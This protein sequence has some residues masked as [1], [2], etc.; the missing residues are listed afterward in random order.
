LE[1]DAHDEKRPGDVD[2]LDRL[3]VWARSNGATVVSSETPIDGWPFI[4]VYRY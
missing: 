1:V 4:A 2:L 3:V